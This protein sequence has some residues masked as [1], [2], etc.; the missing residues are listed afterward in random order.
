MP[1]SSEGGESCNGSQIGW[2]HPGGA[3]G[4]EE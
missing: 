4:G 2:P 3:G 1:Y